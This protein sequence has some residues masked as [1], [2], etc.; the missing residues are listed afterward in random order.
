MLVREDLNRLL[1]GGVDEGTN[2]ISTLIETVTRLVVQE[3]LEAEQADYLGGRG[4]YERRGQD[5]RGSRNGYEPGR[6]RSAEG[7]VDVRVPQVRDAG[8]T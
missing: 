1:A 8:E 5:Q 2:I 6:I 7:A 3:L 4:H